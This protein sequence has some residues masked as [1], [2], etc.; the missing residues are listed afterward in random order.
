MFLR[1]VT[2]FYNATMKYVRSSEITASLQ[3]FATSNQ[4]YNSNEIEGIK[5]GSAH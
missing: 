4:Y 3:K 1:F 5:T 2:C